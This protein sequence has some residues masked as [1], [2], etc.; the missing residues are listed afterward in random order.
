MIYPDWPAAVPVKAVT[1]TR[2]GGVSTA[3]YD[4]LNLADHVGDAAGAVRQN[5]LSIQQ[6]LKL[7]GWPSWLNQVHGNTV[8]D[9]ASSGERP[10]ADAGFTDRPGV[11]CAVLTADC[12]P[13]LFCDRSGTRVAAAH[14]GWRGLAAGILESTV[15][16]FESEPWQLMAWLGPAIGARAFEVGGEVRQAFVAQHAEAAS[17]FL[18]RPNGR[19]LADLYQLA[20]IRLRATGVTAVYGGGFC[21]YSDAQ[22]F[23]SYRRDG[24][25]GRM[26]SLIWLL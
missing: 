2:H 24:V 22:R 1:T 12:L 21:T 26:A 8:V 15:R 11:V 20:R 10:S 4:S 17:A 25:T 3:P 9:A 16:A 13:V 18:S 23:Y 5:R 14:A 6:Q 19:W 7:P